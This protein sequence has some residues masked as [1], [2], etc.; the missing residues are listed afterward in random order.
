[1]WCPLS[2]TYSVSRPIARRSALSDS[3]GG[4]RTSP[5]PTSTDAEVVSSL[6][7]MPLVVSSVATP[8]VCPTTVLQTLQQMIAT[9]AAIIHARPGCRRAFEPGDQYTQAIGE[10]L[11]LSVP[12]LDQLHTA[13]LL[14]DLGKIAK[15][16]VAPGHDGATW[17]HLNP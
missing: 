13:G 15:L 16:T 14:H 11:G 3:R 2:R 7:T 5:R 12:E 9:F 4:R 17:P 8:L 6:V 1:M 10:Q